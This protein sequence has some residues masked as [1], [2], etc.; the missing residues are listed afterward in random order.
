MTCVKLMMAKTYGLRYQNGAMV[1]DFFVYRKAKSCVYN[2][3]SCSEVDISRVVSELY[4]GRYNK[5]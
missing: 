5:K 2:M 1:S 4:R 3:I